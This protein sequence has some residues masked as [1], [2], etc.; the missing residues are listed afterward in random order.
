MVRNRFRRPLAVTLLSS[1]IALGTMAPAFAQQ[2]ETSGGTSS[3]LAEQLRA[4]DRLADAA[5]RAD[6]RA[7][8]WQRSQQTQ[9]ERRLPPFWAQDHWR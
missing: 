2:A 6:C 9:G 3:Y 8:A 1:A 7:A 5:A 4:C